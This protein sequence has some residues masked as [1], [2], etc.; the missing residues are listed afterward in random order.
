[1]YLVTKETDIISMDVDVIW[2]LFAYFFMNAVYLDILYCVYPVC[3]LENI[4]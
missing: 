4:N 3:I 1:M 2:V